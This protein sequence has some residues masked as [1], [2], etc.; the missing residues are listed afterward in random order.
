M[1]KQIDASSKLRG[2]GG[3][4][5]TLC[6]FDDEF[7]TLHDSSRF[8]SPS[9]WP[10]LGSYLGPGPLSINEVL[11]EACAL[12]TSRARARNISSVELE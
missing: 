9:R 12:A 1:A 6:V 11:E 4:S 3:I 7:K 5:Q 10:T 8:V 2:R